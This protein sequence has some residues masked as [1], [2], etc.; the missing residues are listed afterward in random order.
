MLFPPSTLEQGCI[1]TVCWGKKPLPHGELRE[2]R[3]DK[4]CGGGV[5]RLKVE[6]KK[7]G[8]L[9]TIFFF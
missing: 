7:G 3:P 8:N 1:P 4:V 6:K 5:G 9:N 2:Y